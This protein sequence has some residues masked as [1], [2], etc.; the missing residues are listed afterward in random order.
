VLHVGNGPSHTDVESGPPLVVTDANRFP[1]NGEIWIER[2]D[3]Q[4]AKRIQVACE[5]P[6]YNTNNFVQDRHL[7]AFLRR[8]FDSEASR[9]EGMVELQMLI[10]LSR[11]VHP[12]TVGDRYCALIFDFGHEDSVIQAIQFRGISPDVTLTTQRDWL[13]V[14]DGEELRKLMP[15]LSKTKRMHDRVRRAYWYH[16]YAMR[17]AYLDMRWPL[18]VSGLEALI[19]T[20]EHN[21][22]RQF[23]TGVQKLANHFNVGLTAGDLSKAYK[24]RSKLVHAES[25]LYNLGSVLPQNDHNPLYEKL[26]GVLRTTIKQC[27]VDATFGSFFCD[28]H[29]VQGKWQL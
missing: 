5:P 16:E 15:W 27:L 14:G 1:L 18:V 7:Y 10:A 24:L 28:D 29:A 21:N 23:C 2:L 12:T 22:K 25:F 6:H 13:S 17:S 3:E 9:Y 8:A 19:S 11:L 4:L 26:E 20:G